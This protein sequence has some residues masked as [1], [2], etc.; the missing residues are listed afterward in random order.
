MCCTHECSR[1]LAVLP[2]SLLALDPP[3]LQHTTLLILLAGARKLF[4]TPP[5]RCMIAWSPFVMR[6]RPADQPPHSGDGALIQLLFTR[7][8][9]H[10]C[11]D[12]HAARRLQQSPA[13][14]ASSRP[15]ARC[16]PRPAAAFC[17][18]PRRPT[19]AGDAPGPG[20][21]PPRRRV[22]DGAWEPTLGVVWRSFERGA[23]GPTRPTRPVAVARRRHGTAV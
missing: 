13:P 12:E 21:S 2:L 20:L 1:V 8:F 11:C 14:I 18:R 23:G 10:C 17:A 16:P 15:P 9:T 7:C 6:P 5:Y 22:I 4:L 19:R 3:S